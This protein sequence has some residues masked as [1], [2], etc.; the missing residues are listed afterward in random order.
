MKK[1]LGFFI[2]VYWVFNSCTN[3]NDEKG[4]KL[5]YSKDGYIKL[6]SYSDG[7]LKSKKQYSLSHK[8]SGYEMLYDSLNGSLIKWKWYDS[9]SRYPKTIIDYERGKFKSLKGSPFI[10][11][12][13]NNKETVVEMVNPPNIK[14]ILGYRDFLNQAIVR[15]EA[16]E[17][18]KS[19][20]TSWVK[21]DNHR[22]ENGH[23]Y[24]IYYYILD[25]KKNVVDSALTELVP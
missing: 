14:Y 15:Q 8:P 22:Y 17:P 3:T 16:Y 23:K 4:E 2:C 11:A 5:L 19:S 9:I 18:D 10:K 7:R 12:G 24:F 13:L 21:L 6:L 20:T 25:S 1:L